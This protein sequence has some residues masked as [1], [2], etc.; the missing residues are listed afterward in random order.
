MGTARIERPAPEQPDP[1]LRRDQRRTDQAL[2]RQGLEAVIAGTEDH[3]TLW[4]CGNPL[5]HADE[6]RFERRPDGS[7]GITNVVRC[8]SKQLCI[9]CSGPM[10]AADAAT[11]SWRVEQHFATGGGLA[12]LTVAPRHQR[13]DRLAVNKTML[14]ECFSDTMRSTPMK[15]VLADY[16]YLGAAKVLEATIGEN[17]PHAHLHVLLFLDRFVDITQNEQAPLIATFWEVFNDRLRKWPGKTCRNRNAALS[18]VQYV[19]DPEAVGGRRATYRKVSNAEWYELPDGWVRD[20][21]ATH[22]I[23]FIPITPNGSS[24][25]RIAAY[26]GKIQLE[27]TRSDLKTGKKSTSRTVFQVMHDYATEPCAQDAAIITEF[28]DVLKGVELVSWTTAFKGNDATYGD[29]TDEY[30]EAAIEAWREENNL[31]TEPDGSPTEVLAAMTPELH[32]VARPVRHE[33]LPLLYAACIQLEETP[34]VDALVEL[35]N[36]ALSP[37]GRTVAVA[38]ADEDGEPR[39]HPLL[40]LNDPG[41]DVEPPALNRLGEQVDRWGQDLAQ[42]RRA[43]LRNTQSTR[44]KPGERRQ[45]PPG[46]WLHHWRNA[47]TT[48]ITAQQHAADQ[49]LTP[50]GEQ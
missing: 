15:R 21:D 33:G 38:L 22:G 14:T 39:K 19:P 4:D 48:T 9:T 47:A 5:P 25:A 32:R 2:A 42:Q 37:L 43:Q 35:F 29:P 11:V 44:P 27:L 10:R 12:M 8:R 23:H 16:G 46:G 31:D 50:Q 17:G 24:G 49:R 26:V 20:C 13:G 1:K 36:N 45:A 18:G 3:K 34:D 7:I 30:I 40:H 28:V 6:T 41:P